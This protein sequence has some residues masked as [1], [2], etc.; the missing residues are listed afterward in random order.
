[1]ELTVNHVVYRYSEQF[2]MNLTLQ[3][4]NDRWNSWQ[5]VR[6]FVSNALD[7][8]GGEPSRIHISEEQGYINIADDGD[9]FPIVYAKRIGASSSKSDNDRIGQFGEGSKMA[10]LTCVRQ[11]IEVRLASQDWLIIPRVVT[12]EENLKVMVFDIYKSDMNINGTL[13]SIEV[14]SEIK[15]LLEMRADYFLHFNHTSPLISTADGSL[16]AG[17]TQNKV[18]NKG[19][20]IKDITAMYSYNLFIDELNRDRD[21]INDSVLESKMREI[22]SRIDDSAIIKSYWSESSSCGQLG[23]KSLLIEFKY[24]LYPVDDVSHQ[25]VNIFREMFGERSVICTGELASKEAVKLNYVPVKLEYYGDILAEYLGI[26]K[27]TDVCGD[28]YEFTWAESLTQAEQQRLSLYNQVAKI[29]EME[30]PSQIKVYEDYAKSSGIVGI[31]DRNKDMIGIKRERLND[32]IVQAVDTWIHEMNHRSTGADDY[33]REFAD[34]L[35]VL[36]A[37]LVIRLLEEVGM[38]VSLTLTDRGFRLPKDFTYSAENLISTVVAA[39]DMIIIKTAGRTLKASLSRAELKTYSS[40]R[41]VTFYKGQFYI[42]MPAQIRNS[43][44]EEVTFQM[45]EEKML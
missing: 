25:W 23:I 10:I 14:S 28:E 24:Y 5:I 19:V 8:V 17:K 12:V 13:V 22:W 15:D 4:E 43:L 26:K 3:Y 1:M 39:Q 30:C 6:E 40:Q 33:D 29:I 2:D 11:G 45:V 27:D 31:Y 34:G 35:T 38:P 9:G 36:A 20:Y 41:P 21:I 44:P 16:Y 18:Y 32:N 37:K 42:N 7:A